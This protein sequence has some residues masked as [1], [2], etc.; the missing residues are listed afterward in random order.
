MQVYHV[1]K[2]QNPSR[3]SLGGF[4]GVVIVG[5]TSENMR[6]LR[7]ELAE[8]KLDEYHLFFTNTIHD[9]HVQDLARSDLSQVQLLVHISSLFVRQGRWQEVY[10]LATTQRIYAT[11]GAASTGSV[12]R[13]FPAQP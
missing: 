8:A 6:L 4:R 9:H 10:M 2:L 1:D 7:Q 3:K 12:F 11:G 5:P 13:L